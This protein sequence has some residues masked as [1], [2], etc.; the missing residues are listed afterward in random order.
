M[1]KLGQKKTKRTK[2]NPV[3]TFIFCNKDAWSNVIW[4][5]C[6]RKVC[7]FILELVNYTGGAKIQH[8]HPNLGLHWG[9]LGCSI[10]NLW[11]ISLFFFFF[12]FFTNKKN[13]WKFESLFIQT[14]KQRFHILVVFHPSYW[15]RVLQSTLLIL[16]MLDTQRCS[17]LMWRST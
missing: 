11:K 5:N 6:D 7:S 17:C 1:V 8:N 2:R 13:L 9:K 10:P 4:D 14:M 16:L 15:L 12:F 3:F